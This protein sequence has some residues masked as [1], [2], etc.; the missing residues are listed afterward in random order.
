MVITH[1]INKKYM[2]KMRKASHEKYFN[3]SELDMFLR[4]MVV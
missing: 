4:E 1:I 3:Y 2:G